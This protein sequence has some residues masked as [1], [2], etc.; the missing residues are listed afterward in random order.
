MNPL[1]SKT[2][3]RVAAASSTANGDPKKNPNTIICTQWLDIDKSIYID[4]RNEGLI[5]EGLIQ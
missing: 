1:V 5:H 4:K 3:G 2:P